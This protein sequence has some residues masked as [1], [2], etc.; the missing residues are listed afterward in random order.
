[1]GGRREWVG[2]KKVAESADGQRL[3]DPVPSAPQISTPLQ[4]WVSPPHVFKPSHLSPEGAFALTSA[5]F[6]CDATAPARLLPLSITLYSD[7]Q[8]STSWIS[9]VFLWCRLLPCN[10][11]P[12][13]NM[14]AHCT[15]A[16]MQLQQHISIPYT[17]SRL[18][19]TM[20]GDYQLPANAVSPTSSWSLVT[21]ECR[22]KPIHT[23]IYLFCHSRLHDDWNCLSQVRKALNITQN[24][25]GPTLICNIKKWS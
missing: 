21:G 20:Q 23:S 3:T 10:V 7:A 24:S 17:S 25:F 22:P 15:H 13:P 8:I 16:R 14:Y 9:Q 1:M 12:S 19:T 11:K 18:P 6:H 5:G 2:G 4:Y